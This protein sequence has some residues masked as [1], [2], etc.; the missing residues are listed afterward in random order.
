M[1]DPSQSILYPKEKKTRWEK[2]FNSNFPTE[3]KNSSPRNPIGML[4]KRNYRLQKLL[5]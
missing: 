3:R 5:V 4:S 2:K 1:S